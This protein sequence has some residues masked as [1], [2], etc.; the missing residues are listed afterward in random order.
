MD[1]ETI[2]YFE[3]DGKKHGVIRF[4]SG[5]RKKRF[6]RKERIEY[7]LSSA[8]SKDFIDEKDIFLVLERIKKDYPDAVIHLTDWDKFMERYK[9]H[10]FWLIAYIDD[11]GQKSPSG[12]YSSHSCGNVEWTKDIED[13]E[14]GMDDDATDETVNNIRKSTGKKVFMM[15]VYLDL[16]NGLLEP[17]FMITCTGK[18]GKQETKYF[19]RMEGA[20]LRL[21]TTSD[22]AKKFTYKEVLAMFEFLQSNNKNFLY[23]VLPVFKENVHYKQLENYMRKNKVSRMVQ[24]TTK[25]RWINR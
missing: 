22:A 1:M 12:Y 15:P 20:R 14:I 6:L 16:V 18:K 8:S 5:Y 9:K 21:N 25:L 10:V 7:T 11:V 4:V 23:A 3:E 2:I 24:M 19:A 17:N 13:A